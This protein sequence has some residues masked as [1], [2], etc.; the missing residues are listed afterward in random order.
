VADLRVKRGDTVRLSLAAKKADGTVQPLTGATMK[1]TAKD[2]LADADGAALIA[3]A[4]GSGIVVDDAPNGLATV[5]IA[6][7]LTSGFTGPRT[8]LWDVQAIISGETKTLA[9]GKLFVLPDVTRT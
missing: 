8:L 1:F 4:I 6:S 2:R 5:T 3:L 9:E 7:G